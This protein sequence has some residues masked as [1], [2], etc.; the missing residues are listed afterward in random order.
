MDNSTTRVGVKGVYNILATPFTETGAIDEASIGSLVE[1]VLST[2]V[3]GLTVLGVAGEAHK[4]TVEER[5]HSL[6]RRRSKP[7]TAGFR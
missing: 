3:D 6:L 1:G 4:L 2:G 7:R 5:S